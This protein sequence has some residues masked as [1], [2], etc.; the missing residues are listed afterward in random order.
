[1]HKQHIA[2]ASYIYGDLIK[3]HILALC[4]EDH[5]RHATHTDDDITNTGY[6][7]VFLLCTYMYIHA[8]VFA[9]RPLYAGSVLDLHCLAPAQ[10]QV[11]A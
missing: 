1:M 7:T 2:C 6:G 9:Q 4:T 3:S 5:L 8:E 10:R 11:F